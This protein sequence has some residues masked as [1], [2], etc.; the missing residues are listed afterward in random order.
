MAYLLMGYDTENYLDPFLEKD[1]D[2]Q[3]TLNFLSAVRRVHEDLNAPCTLFIC[4]RLLEQ[5]DVLKTLQVL[6]ESELFDLQQHTYSH[7]RLKTVVE[8]RG[9]EV[10]FFPGASLETIQ[11]EVE[12]TNQLFEEKLGISCTGICGPFCY[13][14]G[15]MDRPDILEILHRARIRFTRTYARNEHDYNPVSI[16]VQPFMYELQGFPDI[17]EIPSQGWQDIVLFRVNGWDWQGYADCGRGLIDEIA[18]RDLVWSVCQHDWTS[19]HKDPNMDYT[20][21]L[22]RYA[23]EKGVTVTSHKDF[24]ERFRNERT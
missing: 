9:E 21:A 23:Q 18:Q 12:R 6:A 11:E 22:I 3:V 17:L 20:W 4:G 2:W 14:R 7:Q 10:L 16:D 8:D 19:I 15:L 13:Y 24:S 5:P 1:L